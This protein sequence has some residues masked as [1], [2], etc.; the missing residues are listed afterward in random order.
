MFKKIKNYLSKNKNLIL[1]LL[2]LIVIIYLILPS[3]QDIQESIEAIKGADMKW[4]LVANIFYYLTIPMYAIQLLVL[5]QSKL[6]AWITFKV[7]MSV[8]FINKI[9][10]SSISSFSINSFY[11]YKSK[12]N[13]SQVASVI[14]MKALTSSIT[15]SFLFIFSVIL[16]IRE[17]NLPGQLSL[18][19]NF[20]HILGLSIII[21]IASIVT[22]LFIY[23]SEKLREILKNNAASFWGKFKLYK[24][25]PNDIIIASITGFLAP[26]IGVF[27]LMA[28]AKSVGME[29]SYLQSFIVYTL[30]TTMANLVPTPGGI[31]GAEAGL[32]AGF[33]IL[34]FSSSESFAATMI[35]R[36]V[37]F[38]IPFIPGTYFFLDLRKDVLKDFSINWKMGK[39]KK[40]KNK[41]LAKA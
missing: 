9:L 24:D 17:Y 32:Y 19:I 20:S 6:N 37:S 21:I 29:I 38:W 13:P 22:V 33:T 10:P 39:D 18:N 23:H 4:V 5:A 36:A 27:V 26:A 34:G 15:Y 31:G 12:H 28:S 16:G 35:Y 3:K 41:K 11:L 40:N 1:G 2:I 25:R 14:A 30:G 8:L 7:Q